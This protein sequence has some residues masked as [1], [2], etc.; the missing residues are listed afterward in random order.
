VVNDS[1]VPINQIGVTNFLSNNI[2]GVLYLSNFPSNLLHLNKITKE[3]N[4]NV[5]FSSD[6]VIFQDIVTKNTIGEET[7]AN[8]LYYLD[9]SNKALAT[10]TVEE[11]NY[12][13]GM[14]AMP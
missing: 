13:I 4:C 10:N 14:W 11:N 9:F 3:L 5:I 1:K 2:S 8:R 7:L 6:I 12:G